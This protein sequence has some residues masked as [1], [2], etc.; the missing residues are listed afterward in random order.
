MLV[1]SLE[2][3]E[4]KGLIEIKRTV[5]PDKRTKKRIYTTN[6]GRKHIREMESFLK[7]HLLGV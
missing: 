1:D 4:K 2:V 7:L 6:K 3:L 5:F